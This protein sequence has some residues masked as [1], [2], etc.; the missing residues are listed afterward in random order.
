MLAAGYLPVPARLRR[1]LFLVRAVRPCRESAVMQ[2]ALRRPAGA[3]VAREVLVRATA[4][5]ERRLVIIQAG[6]TENRVSFRLCPSESQRAWPVTID[7]E[8]AVEWSGTVRRGF[9]RVALP[10]YSLEEVT[11][12]E[13]RP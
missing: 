8:T 9:D 2:L 4:G 6:R 12:T 7:A 13:P 5:S 11:Q 10:A 3:A 1:P